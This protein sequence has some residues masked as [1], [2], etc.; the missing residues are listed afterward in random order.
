MGLAR[1]SVLVKEVMMYLVVGKSSANC[2]IV[3]VAVTDKPSTCRVAVPT[4]IF[5]AL[6]LGGQCGA[7]GAVYK[8]V[9]PESTMPVSLCG[10]NF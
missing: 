9:S 4:L 1:T 10:G 8:W 7:N 6:V 3:S 2:G 5:E